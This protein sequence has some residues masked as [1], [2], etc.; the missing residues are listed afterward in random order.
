MILNF[1]LFFLLSLSITLFAIPIAIKFANKNEIYQI[2]SLRGMHLKLIPYLGGLAIFISLVMSFLF[3]YFNIFNLILLLLSNN[4]LIDFDFFNSFS[5]KS[6]EYYFLSQIVFFSIFI[7][8][9]L[10]IIDDFFNLHVLIKFFIQIFVVFILVFYGDVKIE[11]FNGLFGYY[12]L[13]NYFQKA[14]SI[15]VMVFIINSINLTDG[16]DG[17]ASSLCIYILTVFSFFFFLNFSFFNFFLA[18]VTIGSLLGFLYF[19]KSP[20]KIFMGDSGS[21]VLGLIVAY[22]SV[23]LCNLPLDNNGCINPVFVLCI[24]AYPS[25]DTLRV[26]TTRILSGNSPFI[27]DRNHIHHLIVDKN[28]SH[29]WASFFAVMYSLVLSII[30]YLIRDNI[31]LSFFLTL[32]F[33]ILFIV[34]PMASFTRSTTKKFLSFFK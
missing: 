29:S 1:L 25:I 19:N 26:F 11:S 21:L 9:L 27:A 2:I 23:S 28:F 3:A 16:L 32:F 30:C 15:F 22:L 13:P 24:L 5:I 20:A 10:G 7:M 34:L 4:N 6:D 33:A 17:L 18:I 31:N 12:L 8:F 14:F